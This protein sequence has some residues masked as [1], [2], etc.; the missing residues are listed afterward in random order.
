MAKRT[1]REALDRIDSLPDIDVP[2]HSKGPAIAHAADKV[3]D[4]AK[5]L[6]RGLI[7]LD[8]FNRLADEVI[9]IPMPMIAIPAHE[10]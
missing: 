3:Y 1:K 2:Y 7:M 5:T 6:A 9:V 4:T 8:P 10:A